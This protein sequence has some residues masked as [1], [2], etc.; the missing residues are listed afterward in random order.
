M[1][2]L[3][4]NAYSLTKITPKTG[5]AVRT[6]T[7]RLSSLCYHRL[8]S[9]APDYLTE[10]LRIYKPTRQ[11]RKSSD[12][13]ILCIP[14]VCRHYLVKD[15]FLMLRRQSGTL[16]LTKSSHPTPSHPSNHHLKL[17]LISS[18]TD[19]VCVQGREKE[20][21]WRRERERGREREN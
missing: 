14:T 20:V 10:L 17:I 6:T 2:I 9:T 11:L 4:A 7:I 16:S 15:H 1:Q 8:N 3:F 18:P 19:C 5:D 13:S 21:E 12:T